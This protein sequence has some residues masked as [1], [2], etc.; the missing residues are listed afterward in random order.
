MRPCSRGVIALAGCDRARALIVP[1]SP[2]WDASGIFTNG[3]TNLGTG[4]STSVDAKTR[5]SVR[6]GYMARQ[7]DVE[8][9]ITALL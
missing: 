2:Q 8:E 1:M 5:V 4:G 7:P 6:G 3:R 9:S